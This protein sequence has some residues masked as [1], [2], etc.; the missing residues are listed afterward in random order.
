MKIVLT[1]TEVEGI[2]RDEMKKR[3][4]GSLIEVRY[5]SMQPFTN[6]SCGVRVE[7]GNRE[8]VRRKK[9]PA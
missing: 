8:I 3:L 5:A 7:V 4:A 2:V 6:G 1:A 9:K